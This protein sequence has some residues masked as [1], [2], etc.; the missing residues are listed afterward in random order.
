MRSAERTLVMIQQLEVF[1]HNFAWKQA[2]Y[3]V[4]IIQLVQ[5]VASAMLMDLEV[6]P[7]NVRG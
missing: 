7:T 5:E 3:S 4:D 6:L 1:F 2:C